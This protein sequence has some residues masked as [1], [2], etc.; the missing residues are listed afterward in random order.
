MRNN[1]KKRILI[2][3]N[4]FN[5]YNGMGKFIIDLSQI[6]LKNNY[7]VIVLTGKTESNLKKIERENGIIIYRSSITFRFNR[8]Y[9]SISL[10]KNFIGI[11][12]KV[13][14]VHFQFP[15]AEILPLTLLTK[16]TPSWK[17]TV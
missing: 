16:K 6:L 14:Y 15:L 3:T 2:V 7:Q 13:D 8:G 5:P 4:F 9:F 1:N 11:Q 12:K 10:I 17:N